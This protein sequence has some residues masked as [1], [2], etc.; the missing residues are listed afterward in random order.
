MHPRRFLILAVS[1]VLTACGTT[2]APAPSSIPVPAAA[3]LDGAAAGIAPAGVLRHIEILASDELR[4]RDTPSPGLEQ[5][6]VHIV[7]HFRELGL[8]PSGDDGTFVQRY[9]YNAERLDRDGLRMELRAA[10]DTV[11]PVLGSDLFVLPARTD[12]VVGVPLFAGRARTGAALPSMA[13][14][15]IVMFFVPDTLGAA[16]QNDVTSALQA[17]FIARAA[18]AVLVLDSV[19]TAASLGMLA[20]QLATQVA[21]LPVVGVSYAM[22]RTL[23][24]RAGADF[25]VARGRTDGAPL[26]L[27]GVTFAVNT[28]V[29]SASASVPNVVAVLRGSDPA[30]QDEYV[31]YSAHFDHVGV[32]RADVSGDSIY[33]GADDNASGTAALLEI[34]RAFTSLERAP[35]RSIMFVLVS[36]EEKGLLGSAHFVEQPP[37]PTSRMVANINVDMIG[38]N[39]PDTVVAIGQEHSSLGPTVQA[40]ARRNADLG[41]V[42][43]HDPWPEEQLF[44]RSD[45]FSFAKKEVPA[46]FFTTGLHEEYHQPGDEAHLID[47][48][49]VA[50]VARLLFHLGHEIANAASRPEWTADGLAEVRRAPDR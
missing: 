7:D 37:V 28:P 14:G 27:E 15:R 35:S 19:F 29:E 46:I 18:A 13:A 12:S 30:L 50:R 45:H 11:R 40:V 31:V 4:G 32:G 17:A 47:T 10:T 33:N 44:Y 6:A 41:L 42:V 38:R 22:G 2:A 3:G 23:F 9:P 8:Q 25:T 16:W 49:K 39:A 34:A 24:E 36:G 5:A 21:P 43:A 48:D 1:A 26:S 20:D